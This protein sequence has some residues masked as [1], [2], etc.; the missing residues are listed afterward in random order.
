VPWLLAQKAAEW[1]PQLTIPLNK[2]HFGAIGPGLSI[3]LPGNDASSYRQ[4]QCCTT[5]PA[6]W[7]VKDN[8]IAH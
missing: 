8:E 3:E 6:T 4:I 2:M 5:S 1:L 7:Q